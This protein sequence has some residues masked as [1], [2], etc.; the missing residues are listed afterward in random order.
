MFTMKNIF[1]N[2]CWGI[3]FYSFSLQLGSFNLYPYFK[4]IGCSIMLYNLW[5]FIDENDCFLIAFKIM[6]AIFAMTI[7]S[8][9]I[10][11]CSF[12]YGFTLIP[13]YIITILKTALFITLFYNFIDGIEKSTNQ[14]CIETKVKIRNKI[15]YMMVILVLGMLYENV[16]SMQWI[17]TIFYLINLILIIR[18]LQ[19]LGN[20]LDTFGYIV[21]NTKASKQRRL[22]LELLGISVLVLFIMTVCINIITVKSIEI[23]NEKLNS[24]SNLNG[25]EA[26]NSIINELPD[27]ELQHYNLPIKNIEVQESYKENIRATTYMTEFIT[28]DSAKMVRFLIRVEWIENSYF[29]G[30]DYISLNMDVNEILAD[31]VNIFYTDCKRIYSTDNEGRYTTNEVSHM[32][33]SSVESGQL[34]PNKDGRYI[35]YIGVTQKAEEDRLVFVNIV[36]YYHRKGLFQYPYRPISEYASIGYDNYFNIYNSYEVKNDN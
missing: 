33:G 4:L 9:I 2:L 20:R 19:E 31:T 26:F 21:K 11:G 16:P 23:S 6:Q 1:K 13:N 10:N 15:I 28:E 36:N 8:L 14:T 5:L 18:N 27:N 30:D 22:K 24:A 35:Y 3:F 34:V 17:L 25:N 32:F 12:L 7:I 29:Y